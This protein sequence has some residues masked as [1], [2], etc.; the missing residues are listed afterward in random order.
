[1]LAKV[2]LGG[3]FGNVFCVVVHFPYASMDGLS[4]QQYLNFS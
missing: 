4:S 1:M 2:R 3:F